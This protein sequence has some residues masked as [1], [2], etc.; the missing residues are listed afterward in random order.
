MWTHQS[1]QR[2]HIDPWES[3]FL[4][5]LVRWGSGKRSLRNR[6]RG[7]AAFYM[8]RVTDAHGAHRTRCSTLTR[9]H[10]PRVKRNAAHKVNI[11]DPRV[12]YCRYCIAWRV[13]PAA[14]NQI[15]LFFYKCYIIYT[16]PRWYTS[17]SVTAASEKCETHWTYSSS[18]CLCA[19]IKESSLKNIKAN[20]NEGLW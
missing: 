20:L 3:S 12:R 19:F 15:C 9:P 13:S 11:L 10:S 2:S 14:A 1:F 4:W 16:M 8:T 7:A 5:V 6:P 18:G 17:S